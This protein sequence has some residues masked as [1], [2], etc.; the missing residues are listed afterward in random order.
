[1]ALNYLLW[2]SIHCTNS[3]CGCKEKVVAKFLLGKELLYDN[4]LSLSWFNIPSHS[5]WLFYKFQNLKFQTVFSFVS[6]S[7]MFSNVDKS[8]L[9]F[10][11]KNFIF[12]SLY[13][14]CPLQITIW[15]H[16]ANILQFPGVCSADSFIKGLNLRRH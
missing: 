2:T 7:A 10:Y 8:S 12:Q 11:Q 16:D 4:N 15:L 13:V 9:Y 5:M 14:Y 6:T 1:M 3:I